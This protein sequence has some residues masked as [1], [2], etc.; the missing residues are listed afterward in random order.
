MTALTVLDGEAAVRA[1]VG[2]ELGTTDWFQVTEQGLHQ[3]AES[4]GD[5]DGA[6]FAI[7]LSNMFLPQIVEVR[8]FAMGVNYGTDAVHFGAPLRAGDRLR[9][10][11]TLVDV[12]EV[13]GGIQTKMVIT[14]DVETGEPA[15]V[16]EALSR[17][18]S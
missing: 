5:P 2:T 6:Y 4:T 7:S 17:W 13:K 16:I 3:F 14:V 15:C 10:S 12:A 1:A 9:G 18:L 11:A 8:G